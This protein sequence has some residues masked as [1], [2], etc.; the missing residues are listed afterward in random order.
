MALAIGEYLRVWEVEVKIWVSWS[1]WCP[2][3]SHSVIVTPDQELEAG[4]RN[5]YDRNMSYIR[6]FGTVNIKY[7]R[8]VSYMCGIFNNDDRNVSYTCVTFSIM[9]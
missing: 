7:D 4:G 3:K 5:E 8:N 9:I 1:L 6:M 2:P